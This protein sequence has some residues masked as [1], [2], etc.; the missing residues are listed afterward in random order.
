M[1]QNYLITALRNF[2]RHKLYSFINIAGLTVGLTCAIFIILFIRDERSYDR[3]IPGTENLYRVEVTFFNAGQ[4][5]LLTSGTSFPASDAMLAEIPEV[6]AAVHLEPDQMT[7]ATGNRQFL[8]QVNV[9]SP[10]FFQIIRL[11]LIAG[12]RATL[13]AQAES[14]VI[15]ESAARKYFGSN[16]AIGQTLKVGGLCEWGPNISGCVVRETSVIVTGVMRDLPH[17]T[18]LSGDVFIPNTSAADPM[19]REEKAKW[20]DSHGFGYVALQPRADARAIMAKLPALIDRNFDPGK[21]MGISLRGSEDM[22]LQLT[23]FRDDHLSTDRYRSLT[24]AGSWT[25]VYGFAAIGV[26]VLLIACFNFT[27]LA[28]ARAMVRAREISLRKVLGARRSQVMVQF[29]SESALIALL[30]LFLALALVEMLLPFYDRMLG[31]PI[32]LHYL[33]DWLLLLALLG[34][35]LVVGLLGGIYPALVLSRFRPAS[36]LRVSAAGQSGS[37]L[38]RSFLVVLQFAVSIGLG[39]AALV[40]LAQTSFARTVDLG[41]NKD[42]IVLIHA[43][44]ME[45]S[46]RES[47][48]RAL[49]AAP[50][51]KGAA[52]SGDTPFSGSAY[53]ATIEIPAV[54]GTTRI[55]TVPVGPKFFSLY[56]IH[57][58]SGRPLS[59]SHGQDVR[60]KE[61][62]ADNVLINRA[63]A[64]RFGYSPQSALGK[65]FYGVNTS[66]KVKK[67]LHV[68]VGVTA[69]FMF[70]GDR[71][72]VVPTFYANI[73]EDIATI[74][75]RVPA[76]G[77]PQALSTIDRIWHGFAPSIAIDRHF[78]DADFERQFLADEQQGKIFA[79]FVGIA[80]FIA[81]LG[82]FGLAAFSTE[83]RTKE[84]GL[85][86]TFGART[87]DIILLLLWQFSIPVL[88]ANLIAWPVAYYYLQ[89]WLEGYAYRISLNPFYF[90]GTGLAALIIAWATV[91]VHAQRVARA[92][93]IHALRYE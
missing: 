7:V 36:T 56:D 75:V 63:A 86:K 1:F 81:C 19:S 78:L 83:R 22:R 10:N 26:L 72:E 15:S 27:N 93:P 16:P 47:L 49:D 12:N 6:K 45:S 50:A 51:L 5:P 21:E 31:K 71:K 91:F 17:N 29:L 11:P 35:A 87:K 82:L 60:R 77:V 44:G 58:L 84:I 24:P 41:L 89:H 42:G 79:L 23:P 30:S 43:R 76:S 3:W 61:S 20:S 40:V 28:T 52:L 32:Q 4:P 74:S 25:T 54:P 46:T 68:I 85:R 59:D 53:N 2:T 90:L 80:I 73:P 34:I 55:R 88:V 38:L 66:A 33:N 8:D 9:V 57:L 65:S 69:D 14:A 62:S 64:E 48:V 13:L 70:E 67:T 39:I 18:Q 92:N 37:G